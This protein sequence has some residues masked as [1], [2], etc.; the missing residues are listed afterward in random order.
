MVA[1]RAFLSDRGC[2]SRVSD[3]RV[4]S[5]VKARAASCLYSRANDSRAGVVTDKLGQTS[6]GF[7]S[8]GLIDV[9]PGWRFLL[10]V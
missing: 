8:F 2:R 5:H 1:V 3:K 10:E 4:R 6:R 9:S 7:D